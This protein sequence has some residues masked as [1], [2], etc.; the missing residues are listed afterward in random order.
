MERWAREGKVEEKRENKEKKTGEKIRH[1][2][3]LL[4]W[5]K[6]KIRMRYWILY[7]NCYFL[8]LRYSTALKS[9][10]SKGS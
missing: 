2:F 4:A 6:Q 5:T 9:I 3:S 10:Y 1:H 8:N 7:L